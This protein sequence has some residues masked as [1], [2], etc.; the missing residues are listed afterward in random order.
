MKMCNV[1]FS[2]K[3][4]RIQCIITEQVLKDEFGAELWYNNSSC[5]VILIYVMS[6]LFLS[7]ISLTMI[8]LSVES[9]YLSFLGF[10]E[11]LDSVDL[12]F[13]EILGVLGSYFFKY[14]PFFP[15][16]LLW[17]SIVHMSLCLIIS[18]RYV[19]FCSFFFSLFSLLLAWIIS[20]SLRILFFR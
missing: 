12:F 20:F 2:V 7:F 16:H 9:L 10:I 15:Y 19:Q 3:N 5:I 13:N 8:C 18:Y 11:F 4:F 17:D 6:F 1:I 14:C